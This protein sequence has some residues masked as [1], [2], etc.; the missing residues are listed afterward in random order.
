[1]FDCIVVGGGASGLICAGMLAHSGMDCAIVERLERVGKKIL[2]TGNGRCNLSN[3]QMTPAAFAGRE[4]FVAGLFEAVPPETVLVHWQEL[5]LLLQE[6]EG[7]I[8]PRSFQAASVLDVLR[9][10]IACPQVTLMTGK[11]VTGI[12][13]RGDHYTIS[14]GTGEHFSGRYMVLAAGGCAAPAMG[15]DGS[16]YPLLQDLGFRIE[17]PVPSLVQVRS[18]HPLLPSLKGIRWR[19][20]AVLIS[21]E[22]VLGRDMGEVLFTDYGLSG[23]PIFQL[24]GEA[25]RV[26][27]AG[28]TA[29][30]RLNLLPEFDEQALPGLLRARAGRG[31]G[32]N[33]QTLFTGIFPRMLAQAVIKSAGLS[34]TLPAGQLQ[35]SG[36]ASLVRAIREMDFPLSGTRGFEQAQVTRG[37][38]STAQIDPATM[39]S[40]L[41]PRM[42]LVGELVDCDGP[43]GGY[44]LHFAAASGM[45]AA[46][47]ILKEDK[48]P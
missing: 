42:Y 5:G 29:A 44:N 14:T 20:E 19:A 12:A 7:R 17:S 46:Q 38:V 11:K 23:I 16:L 41:Y 13:C 9:R 47:S 2:S 10:S 35:T 28:G 3:R 25:A 39:M 40:I 32:E 31:S 30:V 34:P 22:Q 45:A 36:I 24:S 6:E 18:R 21:G 43:C 33:L 48:K 26:L 27:E 8:Y 4:E 37:G 1:M 15:T